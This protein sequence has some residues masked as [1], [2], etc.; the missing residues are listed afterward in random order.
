[1]PTFRP[2]ATQTP[3]CRNLTLFAVKDEAVD[4]IPALNHVVE[5]F[6]YLTPK[7][8]SIQIFAEKNG[9]DRFAQLRQCLIGRVLNII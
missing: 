5:A 4:A 1:M 2:F 3:I 8:F 6:V 7:L 9:F